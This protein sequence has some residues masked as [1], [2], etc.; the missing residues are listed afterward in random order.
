[1]WVYFDSETLELGPFLY[2]GGKPG[3]KLPNL[4]SFRVAK[5]AKGNAKGVKTERPNHRV[6]NKSQFKHIETIEDLW[7]QLFGGA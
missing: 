5:H 1:M 4:E 2:F 7:N 3:E 6:V